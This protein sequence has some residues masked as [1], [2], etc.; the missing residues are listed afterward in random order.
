[1][2]E[3]TIERLEGDEPAFGEFTLA[4]ATGAESTMGI[5]RW[6]KEDGAELILPDPPLDWPVHELGGEHRVLGLLADGTAITMPWTRVS[7]YRHSAAS[8]STL[9]SSR[10]LLGAQLEDDEE[11]WSGV[12]FRLAHLHGWIPRTGIDGPDWEWGEDGRARRIEIDWAPV[13]PVAIH[14]DEGATMTLSFTARAPVDHSPRAAIDTDLVIHVADEGRGTIK[15]LERDHLRPWLVFSTVVADRWDSP[16]LQEVSRPENRLPVRILHEGWTAVPREWEPG[17]HRYLFSSN[18][19]GDVGGLMVRWF[20]LYRRAGLPIAVFAE[21]LRDGHSYSP[22]RLIQLVTALDGYCDAM[23]ISGGDFLEKFKALR[24]QGGA[25]PTVTGCTDDNLDL[26]RYARNYFTHLGAKGGYSAE[27]LEAALLPGCRWAGV[28]M[29]AVLLRQLGFSR[30]DTT[31]LIEKHYRRW[32][33]P[34]GPR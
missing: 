19:V 14:L 12:T 7:S 27:E 13:A 17:R 6:S 9:R 22:G 34:H 11:D 4:G 16:I 30:D 25:D 3:G 10:L 15:S 33:L 8:E 28:L 24:E 31:S 5:L 2:F 23:G 32:P 21:T 29:Q 18:D 26:L 20:D 1:M